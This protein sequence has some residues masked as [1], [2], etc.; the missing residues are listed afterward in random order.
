MKNLL[1]LL[2]ASALFAKGAFYLLLAFGLGLV[3][4]ALYRLAR[5]CE[6][7]GKKVAR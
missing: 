4:C 2:L 5:L 7:S 1:P 3:A 6:I